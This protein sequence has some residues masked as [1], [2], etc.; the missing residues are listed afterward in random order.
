MNEVTDQRLVAVRKVN[1]SEVEV[2]VEMEDYH[3]GTL[4]PFS[5]RS[6]P[7]MVFDLSE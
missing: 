3:H 5:S 7:N 6:A 4:D 1:A 2:E